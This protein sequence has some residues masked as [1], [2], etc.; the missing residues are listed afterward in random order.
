MHHMDSEQVSFSTEYLLTRVLKNVL[1]RKLEYVYFL[2]NQR[3][4]QL[5][6]GREHIKAQVLVPNSPLISSETRIPATK[7]RSSEAEL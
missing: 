4:F 2:P 5:G 7:L 3:L 6:G 1:K